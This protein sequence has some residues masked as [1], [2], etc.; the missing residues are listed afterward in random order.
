[1]N[2][3]CAATASSQYNVCHTMFALNV[4]FHE[5]LIQYILLLLLLRGK[6]QNFPDNVS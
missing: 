6:Q 5:I 1:V 4:V 2:E 3:M